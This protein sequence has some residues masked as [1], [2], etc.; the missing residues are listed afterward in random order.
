LG[1]DG[2]PAPGPA[3][4]AAWVRFGHAAHPGV[5]TPYRVTVICRN[6]QPNMAR[7]AD[8]AATVGL[9]TAQAQ[10]P[11]GDERRGSQA[12]AE[13]LQL[14][15]AAQERAHGRAPKRGKRRKGDVIDLERGLVIRSRR[16]RIF[17]TLLVVEATVAALAVA[18]LVAYVLLKGDSIR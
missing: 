5:D 8:S 3:R 18:V 10:R 15:R 13:S 7:T 2:R 11:D 4:S 17:M 12:L 9:V 16:R 6:A 1:P 14:Q